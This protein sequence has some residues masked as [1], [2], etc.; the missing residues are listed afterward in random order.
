MDGVSM[1]LCVWVWV[2]AVVGAGGG[3]REAGKLSERELWGSCPR[4]P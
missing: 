4:L 2:A 3:R 1:C